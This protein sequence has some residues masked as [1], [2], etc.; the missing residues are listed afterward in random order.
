[1]VDSSATCESRPFNNRGCT[2]INGGSNAGML[3]K[4]TFCTDLSLKSMTSTNLDNNFVACIQSQRKKKKTI[5]FFLKGYQQN[6]VHNQYEAMP[7]LPKI[8][9]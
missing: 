6:V 2:P 3:A 9:E 4:N 5:F 1:M 7:L 8:F